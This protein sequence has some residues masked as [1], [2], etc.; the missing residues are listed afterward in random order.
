MPRFE[1]RF[2]VYEEDDLP[3]SCH[4]TLLKKSFDQLML[5]ASFDVVRA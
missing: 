1:L 3:M 2:S 4:A 5:D